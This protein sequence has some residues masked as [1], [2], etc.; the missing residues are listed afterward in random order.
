LVS[1]NGDEE[2]GSAES[3]TT[4]ERLA[5]PSRAVLV[6]EPAQGTAV[7]TARK[8]VGGFALRIMGVAAHAGLDFS[9]GHSAVLELARQIERV[10]AFTDLKR[11][12]TV[13]VGVVR[14]G[15]RPNVVPAEAGAEI[16][17]RIRRAADG[18]AITRRFAGLH[19]VDPG[20]RLEI[21]GGINRPPLERTAAVASLY[22]LARSV[23]VGLG[24]DLQEAAA[25]GGSD[26]N[27]TAA[28]GV[29]TLDGL[30]A[31]GE[32]AHA[33]NES[34]VLNWLPRRAALLGGLIEAI[35]REPVR[36]NQ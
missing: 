36:L 22:R 33:T 25:G 12:L 2:I 19:P 10:S 29:P 8:G 32:G 13:S 27:F 3:R 31:V 34:V 6:L 5:R 20:C 15:T 18:P 28:L 1:L 21:S 14:G 24:F 35:A 11:G 16:D 7:K 26:G 9:Q 4:T 30:G 23:A 17:V